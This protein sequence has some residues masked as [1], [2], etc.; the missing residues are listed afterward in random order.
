MHRQRQGASSLRVRGEVT[1]AT[2]YKEGLVVG[3][4]SLPGNFYDAHTLTEA[5]EQ[6]SILTHRTPKGVFVDKAYRGVSGDWA[7]EE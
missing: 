2:M 3:M 5:I 7:P 6:V 1:V 4:R